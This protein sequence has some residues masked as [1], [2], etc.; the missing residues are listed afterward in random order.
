MKFPKLRRI[1]ALLL[2]LTLAVGLVAHGAGVSDMGVKMATASASDMPVPGKCGGCGD[3]KAGM[4]T[5]MCGVYCTAGTFLP[6][7]AEAFDVA[8]TSSTGFLTAGV[9]LPGHGYPPDPYPP[10]SAVLS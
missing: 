8:S 3:D 4:P 2:V 9:T 5:G 6:L 7:A 10:R 1:F